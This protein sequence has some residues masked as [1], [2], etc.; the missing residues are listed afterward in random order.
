MK[1]YQKALE[2]MGNETVEYIRGIQVVKIFK[3]NIFSFKRLYKSIKDYSTMAYKYSMSCKK[4]YVL[5]QLLFFAIACFI[6][7][8]FIV[9]F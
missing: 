5:F 9:F 7:P 6:I 1:E 3:T 2:E 4:D 8:I